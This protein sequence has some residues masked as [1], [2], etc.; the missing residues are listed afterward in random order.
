MLIDYLP[1]NYWMNFHFSNAINCGAT[2]GDAAESMV[3]VRELMANGKTEADQEVKEAWINGWIRIG[4]RL[5]RQADEDLKKGRKKSAGEK[6][7]RASVQYS[8]AEVIA[9]DKDPRK[10]QIFDQMRALTLQ[11]I[12]VSGR[13]DEQ[14]SIDFEGVRLPGV[15][16]PA[17]GVD[18]PAPTVVFCNGMHTH[19]EWCF[20]GGL[21]KALNDRGISVLV[22]DHPGSGVARFK[23]KMFHRYDSETFVKAALDHLESRP[24]VDRTRLGVAGGSFGGYY[25]PRAAA[26]DDRIKV[27]ICWGAFYSTNL[28]DSGFLEKWE[29]DRESLS[30]YEQNIV[31][32][33]LARFGAESL[34]D[35]RAKSENFTLDLA[36][37][38]VTCPLLVVHGSND[39]QVPLESAKMTVDRAVN[40]KHAELS[41]YEPSDGGEHHCNLD[42]LASALEEMGDFAAE[43]LGGSL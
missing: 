10:E 30:P 20:T 34:D 35:L 29:S 19:L 26:F 24:D 2:I 4:E 22:W 28:M 38:K 32:E 5:S 31:H 39:V 16:S 18:G 40:S 15:F 6:L 3:E 36:I 13:P 23:H 43:H 14:V 37:D 42:S 8:I 9:Q 11:A 1:D 33:L 21:T 27:C 7:M 25:A 41:V 17:Q 12:E